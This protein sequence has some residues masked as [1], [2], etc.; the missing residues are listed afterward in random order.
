MRRRMAWSTLAILAL[1][2]VSGCR[3][4]GKESR[5]GRSNMQVHYLEIVCNDVAAECAALEKIHGL[6]FGPAVA[7][8][9]G[10]RVAKA[11]DGTQIGVRAPL[12]AHE[13]PVTRTYLAVDDIARAVKDAKAAGGEI[14]YP[15]TRQGD[16]GTW[17]IY[18]LGGAQIG[19]WQK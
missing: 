4:S 7:D 8:L 5:E 19:L 18:F 9:G 12:A 11:P 10:A 2:L 6:S 13:Q 1:V 3:A 16:T 14:A 15:P 17:A